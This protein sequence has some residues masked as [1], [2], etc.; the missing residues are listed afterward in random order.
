MKII[1]FFAAAALLAVS[2]EANAQ[3]TNNSGGSSRSGSGTDGWNVVWAE[4][5]PIRVNIEE[6]DESEHISMS[7]FSVG[8]SHA[9]SLSQETPILLEAGIGMQYA[10]YS[11]N[12]YDLTIWSIKLP[13]NI[14]YDFALPNSSISI[15]P[16]AGLLLRFNV[17]G[18][19]EYKGSDAGDAFDDGDWNRFQIGWHVGVKARF[20]QKFMV[21]VSY[22]SDFSEITD[23]AKVQTTSI[24]VGFAF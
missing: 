16:Y 20:A 14:L 23:D 15:A 24:S 9:F 5:N 3:F 12:N 19:M 6:G 8:F 2:I 4:Y 13:V 10:N 18:P 22:G 7:G 17:A 21:G 11:K 1:K